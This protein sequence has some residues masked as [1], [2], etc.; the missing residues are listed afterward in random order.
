MKKIITIDYNKIFTPDLSPKEMLEL[1]V[2]GG[3]YFKNNFLEFPKSW[4]KN[5]KISVD[6]FDV[7]MN[8]FNIKSGLS[9]EHWVS[10]GWIF[11]EDPIGWFQW[12]CRYSMG[13]RLPDIDKIQIMRWKSFG[14]RHQ[15]GI[16]KNCSKHDYACRPKQRQGLLQWGY[17]PFF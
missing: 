7:N 12:Y 10:K 15:G 17:D 9:I 8:Y 4:F 11:T 13:R 5:A 6:K 14:P 2:F 3:Y 16:K 1:G